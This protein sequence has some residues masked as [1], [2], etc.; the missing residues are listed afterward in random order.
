MP[1]GSRMAVAMSVVG[2]ATTAISIL[3]ACLPPSAARDSALAVLRVVGS[4][5]ALVVFGE[6]FYARGKVRQEREGCGF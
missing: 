1:G 5:L 3:L 6:W 2:F 4:S